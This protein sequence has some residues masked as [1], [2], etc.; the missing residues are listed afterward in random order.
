MPGSF[1][2]GRSIISR[3]LGT[4]RRLARGHRSRSP[5]R[6]IDAARQRAFFINNLSIRLYPSSWR[7]AKPRTPH[8]AEGPH[9]RWRRSKVPACHARGR[10]DYMHE[11]SAR[12]LGREE[13]LRSLAPRRQAPR[14]TLGPGACRS[15][16]AA[17]SAVSAWP[18]FSRTTS[19]A[20]S[21]GPSFDRFALRLACSR[22]YISRQGSTA[23]WLRCRRRSS[24]RL[25]LAL[26]VKSARRS[27]AIIR[28]I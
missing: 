16:A 17:S 23:G 19:R 24:S 11:S 21:T 15:A 18:G 10:T 6:P 2:S 4:H 22:R 26:L 5:A 1:R 25:C 14:N 20:A 3:D 8:V 28:V 12:R 7:G 27:R 9:Q 13:L